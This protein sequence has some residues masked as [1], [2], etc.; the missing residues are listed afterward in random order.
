M[1]HA[2][3][4]EAPSVDEE[5]KALSR[6]ALFPGASLRSAGVHSGA[7]L[8]ACVAA[9]EAV[10]ASAPASLPPAVQSL[11]SAH[12]DAVEAGAAV[13][14]LQLVHAAFPTA[15]LM[16]LSRPL[17]SAASQPVANRVFAEREFGEAFRRGR[18]AYAAATLDVGTLLRPPADGVALDFSSGAKYAGRDFDELE[19]DCVVKLPLAGLTEWAQD[20]SAEGGSRLLFVAPTDARQRLPDSAAPATLRADGHCSRFSVE[21]YPSGAAAYVLAEVYAP[22]GGRAVQQQAQKLL[23]AE[24]LLQFLVAKE[25]AAGVRD[26]VLGFVFMGPHMDAAAAARLHATLAHYSE[27]LPCLWAL[28]GGGAT[29]G[30]PGAPAVP[31]LP[32]RL[33]ACRV[34]AAM[35]A[36]TA[37]QVAALEAHVCELREEQRAL[38]EG[39][40]EMQEGQ[41]EIKNLLAAAVARGSEAEAAR[42]TSGALRCALM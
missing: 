35:P 12:S 42:A 32:C 9:P 17:F 26:V 34:A 37:V 29:A 8:L 20:A 30:A 27:A 25:G 28:Q 4:G 1:P 2:A 18:A 10:A 21:N 38:R 5:R 41:R 40:R 11:A 14:F 7:L 33:L 16:D 23:Q 3:D 22:L 13:A 24:R 15:H 19:A 31:Q 39:Q 36:L 6:D